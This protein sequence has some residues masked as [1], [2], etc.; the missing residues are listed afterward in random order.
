MGERHQNL[1]KITVL[2]SLS[3]LFI[4]SYAVVRKEQVPK[5]TPPIRRKRFS[6]SPADRFAT[7][8]NMRTKRG[9]PP[10]ERPPP[11]R[12]YSPTSDIV[13]PMVRKSALSLDARPT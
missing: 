9:T 1:F 8:P 5:P 6:H 4:Y 7:M 2:I 12:G 3:P 10:P 13:M 11:P